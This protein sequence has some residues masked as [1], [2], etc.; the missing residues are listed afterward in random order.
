MQSD[1]DV[2]Q[3]HNITSSYIIL[4]HITAQHSTAQ[5]TILPYL[6]L[7]ECYFRIL[8]LLHITAHYIILPYLYVTSTYYN[9]YISQRI[10]LYNI[11]LSYLTCMLF[12][13]ITGL[14]MCSSGT[15]PGGGVMGAPGRNCAGVALSD[16]GIRTL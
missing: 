8:Q 3:L 10:I 2:M 9:F 14:Y 4:Y 6:I 16:L 11:I 7:P 12:P 1:F 15:H 13:H 5:H